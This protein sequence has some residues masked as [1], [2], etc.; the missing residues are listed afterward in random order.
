MWC[1]IITN[2]IKSFDKV[3]VQLN[4]KIYT[5]K[6]PNMVI[7][8]CVPLCRNIFRKDNDYKFHIFPKNKTLKSMWVNKLRMGKNPSKFSRVCSIHFKPSDYSESVSGTY[9]LQI[10]I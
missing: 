6:E 10:V 9:I 1:K 2:N 3:L 5:N 7:Y 8:C 4:N